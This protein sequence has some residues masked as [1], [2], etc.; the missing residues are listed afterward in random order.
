MRV[1]HVSNL[2]GGSELTL[3]TRQNERV[4]ELRRKILQQQLGGSSGLQQ[5]EL[6]LCC[7]GVVLS[8]DSLL[9][10]ALNS[11]RLTAWCPRHTR[12]R[13]DQTEGVARAKALAAQLGREEMLRKIQQCAK[14]CVG[15]VRQHATYERVAKLVAFLLLTKLLPVDLIGPFWAVCACW[16][17]WSMGFR[18]R[19]DG[20][21]SAY[22][23][24]NEGMQA[25][26]GQIRAEDLQRDM[27]GM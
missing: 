21:Q 1:V 4:G 23:V 22:T 10:S 25:L 27:V 6:R 7:D 8:D 24:F 18:E 13:S 2:G 17:L 26:P 3:Q 12:H 19:S 11:S 16:L 9:V 20:E 5:M 14:L 15:M